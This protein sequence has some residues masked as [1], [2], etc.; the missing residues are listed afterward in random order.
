M[1]Q[2]KPFAFYVEGGD[3]TA[4]KYRDGEFHSDLS[5]L[6]RPYS[7]FRELGL[8]DDSYARAY[9]ACVWLF[10][11]INV[12]VL[13]VAEVLRRAQ[14][15]NRS[16]GRL[17]T[18]HPYIEALELAYQLYTQDVY[19]AWAY[20]KSIYGE[21]YV[22]KV[23]QPI[24]G[25][26]GIPKALRV[27]NAVAAEPVID[28][29][30]IVAY[31]YNDDA[32]SL[33]FSPQ[34]IVFDKTVNPLDD[35]RGY[36]L[37]AAAMDAVN[38][39]RSILILTRAH[40]KNNARPGLIFTPKQG[41]LSPADVDLIQ[42]TLAED[43]KGPQN[44]G[45]PLLMPTAFDVTVA[46]PPKLTDVDAMADQQK[47]RICSVVG[48]PVALVDYQD[49][50]FQLSPEQKSN[51]YDLT[52]IPEAEQIVRIINAQV[53]PF[54]DPRRAVELKLPLDDIRAEL[55]DPVQ[56]TSMYSTQLRDGAITLNEYRTR[57]GHKAVADGDVRFVPPGVQ[58]VRDGQLG[59]VPAAATPAAPA[60]P[61]ETVP[62]DTAVADAPAA[63]ADEPT[64]KALKV[65]LDFGGNADLI[66]LQTRL[67]ALYA[68][69]EVEWVAPTA[70][71]LTL[72]EAPAATD[73][74]I[75]QVKAALAELP[76][77]SIRIGVGS[78]RSFDNLGNFA[79]RLKTRRNV[80]LSELQG[81]VYDLCAEAGIATRSYSAPEAFDPHFTMG[82]MRQRQAAVPYRGS[83]AVEPT[84]LVLYVD[85]EAVWRSGEQDAA[86]DDPEAMKT[87]IADELR[88]WRKKATQRGALKA[89]DVVTMPRYLE[90]FIREELTV[91]GA[92]ADRTLIHA[93]FD[94]AENIAG[95]SEALKAYYGGGGT[96]EAFRQEVEQL[97]TAANA[98][99]TTRRAFAGKL[100]AALRNYGLSAFRDGMA[101]GGYNPES[102]STDDVTIFKA[103]LAESSD[104]VS[105]V[106]SELFVTG[107]TPD[108][109]ARSE[110]W[111][112]KSLDDIY[113][114]GLRIG[115][116]NMKGTWLL[117]ATETHCSSNEGGGGC[118]ERHQQ[119][120]TIDEWGKVGFPRDR[121]LPCGG[122][123]CD[124]QIFDEKGNKIGAR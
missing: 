84:A 45:Q 87:A 88:Q 80:A 34:E 36:S 68:G 76:P 65:V 109:A 92:K 78:L 81:D 122:W 79:L 70:F 27:L 91:I 90:T 12:R 94:D 3:V 44:T 108:P 11:A 107:N 8:S 102:L 6:T 118:L 75:E 2:Y 61:A 119:T 93:V 86:V 35:T 83:V 77:P 22:E 33:T 115:A 7:G 97:I 21:T 39:D 60:L 69:A 112:N 24:V 98:D 30:T 26:Y 10:R 117:G 41:R 37:I 71:G 15:I 42:T 96:R 67:K 64:G 59:A 20:S 121:R 89:F 58:I 111:V 101:A 32:G 124:C 28:R 14:L 4:L 73:E 113:F 9:M 105:N 47:R 100:R 50:A 18:V 123:K 63:K 1:T 120:K 104:Y 99:D 95:D 23:Q 17:I 54:F 25:N 106:G 38:I 5:A 49:M 46:D 51:F 52:L 103:W 72:V 43:A 66:G 114:A 55:G 116:P 16:D 53:L 48:V 110:L 74:Q 82:H 13:K 62:A 57:L 31:R 85:G 40:L 56:R 29:G 19:A